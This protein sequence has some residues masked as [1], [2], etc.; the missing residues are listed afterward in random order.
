MHVPPSEMYPL[1]H[2]LELP[3]SN[4]LFVNKQPTYKELNFGGEH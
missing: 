2:V 1:N 4:L 3:P